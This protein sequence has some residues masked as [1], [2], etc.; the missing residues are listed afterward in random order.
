MA[1]DRLFRASLYLTLLL[2]TLLL[3]IDSVQD[4]RFGVLY[5]IAVCRRPPPWRT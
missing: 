4:S 2:A 3:T 1:F 5:P